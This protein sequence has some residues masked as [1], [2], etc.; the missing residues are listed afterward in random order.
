MRFP[1]LADEPKW[2]LVVSHRHRVE[3]LKRAKAP[4]DAVELETHDGL[5]KIYPGAR[6]VGKEHHR[7]ITKG[8]FYTVVELGL[9]RSELGADLAVTAEDYRK[10]SLANALVYYSSQGRTLDGRVRLYV[11]SQYLS[12]RA[13]TVGL[14]R[15]THSELID[16]VH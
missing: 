3:L 13:L 9:L 16:V 4:A 1:R 11:G 10:F 2:Q 15:A 5:M 14:Q 12:T 6:L 7:G 8:L